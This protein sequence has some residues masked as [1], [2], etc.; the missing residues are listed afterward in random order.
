MRRKTI[1]AFSSVRTE[2][3][4]LPPDI[5]ERIATEDRTLGGFSESDYHLSD[6]KLR[7]GASR[8]WT[9]LQGVW[10]TFKGQRAKLSA[11][12]GGTQVTR[13][14]WLMPLLQELGYGRI[15]PNRD[16]II[17]GGRT[18]AI[19]HL[20][21]HAPLHLIGCNVD[22]DTR[23]A[24]VVGA[25]R[26]SPHGLVQSFLNVN[27]DSLWGIVSNGHKMRLLRDSASLTRQAFVEFDLES[28]FDSELYSDFILLWLLCHQSR[29]ES[30]R[31]EDCWLEVWAGKAD[32]DGKRALE[33][34]RD[35]V[36]LAVKNLGQGFLRHSKNG[37]LRENLRSRALDKQDYYRQ[38][39]RVVYRLLF[40]F[41]A[42]DRDV[43]L[44]PNASD[45]AKK[46]YHLYYGTKR[47]RKMAEQVRGGRHADLWHPLRIV[48]ERLGDDNGSPS[49]A[50][51]PLGGSLFSAKSTPNLNGCEIA[52]RSL[53][54]AIRSLA[55]V[56]EDGRLRAVDYKNLGSEEL[57][58]VYES[59]L[60][61]HPDLDSSG[62]TFSLK[63]SK[64]NEKKL[65]A[66][67]IRL[68]H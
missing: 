15:P 21:G 6:E 47:L 29:L 54:D 14:R 27:K 9:R 1:F 65:Q 55:F 46:R 13:E 22:L 43:L 57:G 52:N 36:Q 23:T 48:I 37:E 44:D 16:S 3:G 5:L 67:T 64:G 39:L 63:T 11:S 34:L 31:A 38:L 30:P 53:L 26:V 20:Y 68:R 4:I 32:S 61:F 50:L 18:Y 59:L 24:G 7:E 28:I 51:K 10:I 60:E 2:G 58:S 62:S 17:I 41:V 33:V 66:P 49:L 12:E 40:L 25:A 19:S 56:E 42:E 35:G 45:S 8:A